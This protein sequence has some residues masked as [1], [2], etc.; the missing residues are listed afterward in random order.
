MTFSFTPASGSCTMTALGPFFR[1]REPSDAAN[2]SA[3]TLTWY[4]AAVS[5]VNTTTPVVLS[6][7]SCRGTPAASVTVT[8]A[9][10]RAAP[11]GSVTVTRSSAGAGAAASAKTPDGSRVRRNR[12]DRSSGRITRVPGSGFVLL[13]ERLGLQVR[14]HLELAHRPLL[15]RLAFDALRHLVRQHDAVDVLEIGEAHLEGHHLRRLR[16]AAAHLLGIRRS[17]G[18]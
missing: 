18:A 12:S 16:H 15:R 7:G 11:V 9:V 4:E 3:S 2:A 8:L 5:P 10:T 6:T 17:V 14:V 1:S 13:R